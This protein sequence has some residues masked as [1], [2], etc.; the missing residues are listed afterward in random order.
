M[1]GILRIVSRTLVI[2]ALLWVGT[3]VAQAQYW[4]PSNP[5]RCNWTLPNGSGGFLGGTSTVV[6]SYNYSD[7]YIRRGNLTTTYPNGSSVVKPFT[8]YWDWPSGDYGRFIFEQTQDHITCNITKTFELGNV[9]VL[10]AC[11]NG[12]FQYC[13][14]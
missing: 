13:R 3:G 4:P 11:T 2:A 14:P 7:P 9:V 1:K 6:F 12:A 8:L 5:L 10:D